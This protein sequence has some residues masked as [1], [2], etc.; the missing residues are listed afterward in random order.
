MQR[1]HESWAALH[2][3]SF[4]L[5]WMH[6]SCSTGSSCWMKHK[7]ELNPRIVLCQSILSFPL[8]LPSFPS[9]PFSTSVNSGF[10][11]FCQDQASKTLTNMPWQG[12]FCSLL[13]LRKTLC[14]CRGREGFS[15]NYCY[16]KKTIDTEAFKKIQSCYMKPVTKMFLTWPF[17]SCSLR[18]KVVQCV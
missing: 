3:S 11:V 14:L 9:P 12:S 10:K 17:I 1:P 2:S 13:Y 5:L 18:E 8:H 4:Y 16:L 7:L 6:T 15:I